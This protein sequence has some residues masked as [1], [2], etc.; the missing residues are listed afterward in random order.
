MKLRYTALVFNLVLNLAQYNLWSIIQHNFFYIAESVQ[1]IV[2]YFFL[3][4]PPPEK[5]FWYTY[6]C[7]IGLIF[8]TND[9]LDLLLFNPNVFGWNE[10]YFTIGAAIYTGIKLKQWERIKRAK[11]L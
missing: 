4:Y 1:Y 6:L 7:F 10:V 5:Q 3:I 2:L 8:G 11:T 9:L